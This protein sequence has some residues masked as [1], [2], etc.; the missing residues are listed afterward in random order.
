MIK[1]NAFPQRKSSLVRSVYCGAAIAWIVAGCL[2]SSVWRSQAKEAPIRSSTKDVS[3]SPIQRM[4][5]TWDVEQKM[6]PAEGAEPVTLPPAV[7][8][9]HLAAGGFLQETMNLAPGSTAD[10]FTRISC[11][12]YNAMSM[13]YEYFSMDSRMPQMMTER[14]ASPIAPGKL[15]S[16]DGLSLQGGNFVAP[17]WGSQLKVPFRYRLT[18]SGVANERQVVRLYLTPL[19]GDDGEE[20]LGFEYV[21][22]RLSR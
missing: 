22:K 16:D 13:Q 6:W 4:V 10:E 17:R 19:S 2:V 21:Y 5:G 15:G 18:I 1:M 8:Q 11:L 14:S 12:N 9:R 3:S 20:F 7:A